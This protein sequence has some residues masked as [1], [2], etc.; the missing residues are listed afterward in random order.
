MLIVDGDGRVLLIRHTYRRGW[1]LPGG[2]VR[3]SESFEAA[4]RRE[5]RE[6]V[7]VTLLD[8]VDLLGVYFSD[9]EGKFDHIGVYVARAWN[10]TPTVDG[11]EIAE[12]AWLSADAEPPDGLSSWTRRW[13][14]DLARRDASPP[15]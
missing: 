1:H 9:E 6:E 13:L 2:G 7:G 5:A 12:I 4:A 8:P 11:K 14:E 3:R 10:G 15:E